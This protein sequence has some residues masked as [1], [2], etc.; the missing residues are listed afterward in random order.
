MQGPGPLSPPQRLALE[1]TLRGASQSPPETDSGTH[2]PLSEP[3]SG[4]HAEGGHSVPCVGASPTTSYW[5]LST[6][7]TRSGSK[8]SRTRTPPASQT[9]STTSTPPDCLHLHFF[10]TGLCSFGAGQT[11]TQPDCFSHKSWNRHKFKRPCLF[12]IHR[13][14]NS[15]L[16]RT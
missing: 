11:D 7:C 2:W 10:R 1:P 5:N 14:H 6:W 16:F 15:S 4:T 3:V 13:H 8:P 9:C 12:L